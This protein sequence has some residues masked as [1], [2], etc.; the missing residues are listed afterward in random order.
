MNWTKKTVSG[1]QQHKSNGSPIKK[2][3]VQLKTKAWGDRISLLINN[4][5]NTLKFQKQAQFFLSSKGTLIS[6]TKGGRSPSLQVLTAYYL[7]S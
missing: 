6:P 4:Q 5:K 7:N 1:L 2:S 3:T